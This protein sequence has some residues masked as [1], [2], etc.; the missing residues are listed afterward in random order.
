MNEELNPKKVETK[1]K[2]P[3]AGLSCP[4]AKLEVKIQSRKWPSH[5]QRTGHYI[6]KRTASIHNQRF[7][8]IITAKACQ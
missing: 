2:Q 3:G 6:C 1:D 4:Q 5:H 8:G 7:K